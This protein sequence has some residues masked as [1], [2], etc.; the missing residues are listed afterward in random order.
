MKGEKIRVGLVGANVHYGWGARAHVPAL[1]ALPEFELVAVCTQHEETA[2]E[3]AERFG[4]RLTFTDYG[5][6]AR[7]PEVDLVSVSVKAPTHYEVVMAALDAGKHVYCE[8]PLGANTREA[9]AMAKLA[10]QKQVVTMV[11]LQARGSPHLLRLKELLDEGYVGKLLSCH[12]TMLLPGLLNRTSGRAW[13]ADRV[14]GSHTLSI[15]AGHGLDAFCYAVAEF[16]DFSAMVATQ[17][18]ECRL[19]DTGQVVQVTAPDNVLING[20]LTN[21]AVASVHIASVPYHGS[22]FRVELYGTEGTLFLSSREMFQLTSDVKLEGA[23][24]DRAALAE[25]P[26]SDRVTWVPPGTPGGAPFNVA[27]MFRRMAQGIR[28]GS[29]VE[30]DFTQA[31]KRH[32]LLNLI[33]RAAE[34]GNRRQVLPAA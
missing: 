2:R 17:V 33:E 26:L 24:A 11:G 16:R 9:R 19:L 8:W 29:P 32:E 5:E 20:T 3:T 15:S 4:I 7:H 22:G 25:L 14:Q 31:V 10:R 13:T 28:E 34:K 6:M 21:G 18:R 1:L 30:P 12:M 27:Q 23:R